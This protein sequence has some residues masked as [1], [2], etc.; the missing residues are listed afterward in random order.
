VARHCLLLE[1]VSLSGL[2]IGDKTVAEFAKR[3]RN[4][5]RFRVDESAITAE[6]VRTIALHCGPRLDKISLPYGVDP[7]SYDNIKKGPLS[8]IRS[9]YLQD[10]CK[11]IRAWLLSGN[12]SPS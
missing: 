4:L 11:E 8:R 7:Y 3:C 12:G 9:P 6:G 10:K 1:E 5:T 2:K